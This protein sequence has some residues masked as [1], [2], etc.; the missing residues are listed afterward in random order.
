MRKYTFLKYQS[1]QHNYK[2]ISSLSDKD[3]GAITELSRMFFMSPKSIR[4]AVRC[5][6]DINDVALPKVCENQTKL[7]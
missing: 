2:L 6:L 7:F 1:I 4:K 3:T 5:K